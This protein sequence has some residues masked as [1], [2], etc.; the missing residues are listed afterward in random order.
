MVLVPCRFT[1]RQWLQCVAFDFLSLAKV[2]FILSIG[3][4]DLQT[5]LVFT[6]IGNI[7]SPYLIQAFRTMSQRRPVGRD[8]RNLTQIGPKVHVQISHVVLMLNGR[9][10][11]RHDV[12]SKWNG[13]WVWACFSSTQDS[14]HSALDHQWCNAC[15][16]PCIARKQVRFVY[17]KRLN[18]KILPTCF[19]KPP[20][21]VTQHS[22]I[23]S[24]CLV[25]RV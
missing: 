3:G 21:T 12:C 22:M 24:S 14:G 23:L 20:R 6:C 11:S 5:S 10:N 8:R 4:C 1:H 13:A 25:F 15:S 9:L 16:L 17:M 2:A 19:Y 18:F 7:G